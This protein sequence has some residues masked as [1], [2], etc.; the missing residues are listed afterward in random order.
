MRVNRELSQELA[1]KIKAIPNSCWL[2]AV[3]ALA[4]LPDQAA[5]IEG[6]I[7]EG[8]SYQV[9]EYGWLALN[10]EIIDP[11]LNTRNVW[12]YFPGLRLRNPPKQGY[13][14]PF[15]YHYGLHSK[16]FESYQEAFAKAQEISQEKL[17][18]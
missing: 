5:Y 4:Y 11:S 8:E 10:G 15:V 9:I 6:W 14:L 7:V 1:Q 13:L 17:R 2:N 16:Q 3:E 12:E 18:G